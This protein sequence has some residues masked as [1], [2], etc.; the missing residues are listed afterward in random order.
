MLIRN[1]VCYT[2]KKQRRLHEKELK[3]SKKSSTIKKP[4]K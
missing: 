1:K 3:K 2:R 4:R